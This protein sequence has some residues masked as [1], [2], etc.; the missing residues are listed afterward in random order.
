MKKKF[1]LNFPLRFSAF[2]RKNEWREEN[3]LM[4]IIAAFMFIFYFPPLRLRHC[5]R[6]DCNRS[7]QH[8]ALIAWW[9]LSWNSVFIGAIWKEAFRWPLMKI[10]REF[11]ES[12]F[13]ENNFYFRN[14][15]CRMHKNSERNSQL[16]K[17]HADRL[18]H[19]STRS[20]RNECEHIP[21]WWLRRLESPSR[22]SLATCQ[23]SEG[24]GPLGCHQLLG[25]YRTSKRTG[26]RNI[27]L[28][29]MLIRMLKLLTPALIGQSLKSLK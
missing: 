19:T 13:A 26:S 27:L 9:C 1:F 6:L 21:S 28:L 14:L 17:L 22:Q 12:N 2:L 15:S 3:L 16:V 23:W 20:F 5:E 7:Q 4:K 29:S 24:G 8:L 25:T 11:K 18:I 10:P